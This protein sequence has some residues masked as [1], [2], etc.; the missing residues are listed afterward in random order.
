MKSNETVPVSKPSTSPNLNTDPKRVQAQKLGR[1]AE[2]LVA[3]G[4]RLKGWRILARNY[5]T[6]VGELD[7]VAKRR[8]TLIFVEVKARSDQKTALESITTK[9]RGRIQRAAEQFLIHHPPLQVYDIRFDVAL[10]TGFLRF[11]HLSDAWR[12]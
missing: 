4:L 10:V 1:W 11:K 9:Q 2:A 7:L 5:K 12:P 6:Q 8:N 3:W